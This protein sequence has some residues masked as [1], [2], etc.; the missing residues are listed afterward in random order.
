MPH[1]VVKMYAGRSDA[2]KAKLADEL[3]K[4]MIA[5]LQCKE[6][7][8]S[9]AIEDVPAADWPEKVYR[10]DIM[11]KSDTLYRKPGYNPFG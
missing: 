3:A 11:G 7:S 2:E 9:V 5:T 10:P 6:Q 4:A 1:I 8:V